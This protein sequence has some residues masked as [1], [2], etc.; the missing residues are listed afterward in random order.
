MFWQQ[1]VKHNTAVGEMENI[2][3]CGGAAA[4]TSLAYDFIIISLHQIVA[5]TH[6]PD[7]VFNMVFIVVL[8]Q[9]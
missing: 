2:S 5:D 7:K 9:I 3:G 4:G 8:Y 1:T 6:Q